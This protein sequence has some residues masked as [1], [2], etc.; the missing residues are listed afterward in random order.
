MTNQRDQ[1]SRPGTEP[2]P[3][4]PKINLSALA[5]DAPAENTPFVQAANTDPE[6][7]KL[8]EALIDEIRR[9]VAA[10][11]EGG[12]GTA[13]PQ[14]PQGAAGDTGPEGPQGAAGAVGPQG[15]AGAQA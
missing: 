1:K 7:K 9:Q 3:R 6:T 14:G 12:A 8:F 13:G 10:G 4:L 15:P 2:A 11:G 5:A